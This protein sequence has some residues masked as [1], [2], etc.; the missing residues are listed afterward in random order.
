MV[1]LKLSAQE[2]E[3]VMT[4]LNVAITLL[5][6]KGAKHAKE[7]D[8]LYRTR[9]KLIKKE[10]RLLTVEQLDKIIHLLKDEIEELDLYY[11]SA[12]PRHRRRVLCSAR[13]K[14]LKQQKKRRKKKD[15][16]SIY[17]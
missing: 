7:I 13:D 17:R 2:L 10:Q 8:L 14:L 16:R 1:D 3:K 9:D 11:G 4:C 5:H 12:R 15:V 6:L